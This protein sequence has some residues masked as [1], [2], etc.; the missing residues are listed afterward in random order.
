MVFCKIYQFNQSS[1]MYIADLKIL[2]LPVE[3]HSRVDDVQ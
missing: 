2:A 1:M 3:L